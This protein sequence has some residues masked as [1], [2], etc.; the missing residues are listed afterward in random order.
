MLVQVLSLSLCMLCLCSRSS[1]RAGKPIVKWTEVIALFYFFLFSPFTILYSRIGLLLICCCHKDLLCLCHRYIVGSKIGSKMQVFSSAILQVSARK[2]WNP[3]HKRTGI[4]NWKRLKVCLCSQK[5]ALLTGQMK[6]WKCL[7]VYDISA[8]CFFS[9]LSMLLCKIIFGAIIRSFMSYS[10]CCVVFIYKF[11]SLSLSLSLS[12]W[13]CVQTADFEEIN[14]L[15]VIYPGFE[16]YEKRGD[17]S[18]I[19][20]LV[21]Y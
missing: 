2:I 17:P 7:K 15:C 10:L 16:F 11:T 5:L 18:S 20:L 14:S 4:F 19:E 6:A 8:Y 13:L 9:V 1:G 12:S 3:N 21:P